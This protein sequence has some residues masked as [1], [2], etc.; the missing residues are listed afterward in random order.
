MSEI[1]YK[2]DE[3]IYLTEIAEYIENTYSGHYGQNG[4]IQTTEIIV[5]RGRGLDF[6]LGNIDKYSNRYGFKGGTAEWRND[7]LKIIHYAIIAL[8]AHDQK[9]MTS[10]VQLGLVDDDSL[11]IGEIKLNDDWRMNYG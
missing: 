7:L 3:P 5:D 4:K 10:D 8:Y 6:C 9:Y 11:D 2:F 1:D